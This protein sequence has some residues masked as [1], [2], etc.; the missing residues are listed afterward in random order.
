MGGHAQVTQ[1]YNDMLMIL[2][3]NTVRISPDMVDRGYVIGSIPTY[4]VY[5]RSAIY[6]ELDW[7]INTY[8]D[9]SW[10]YS[11]NDTLLMMHYSLN[12]TCKPVIVQHA[13]RHAGGSNRSI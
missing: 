10:W 9:S 4:Q 8:D 12:T 1:N 7:H 2:Q 3:Q 11:K 13:E 6:I 5:R